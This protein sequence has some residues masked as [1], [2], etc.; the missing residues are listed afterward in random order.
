MPLTPIAE[1][2]W[3]LSHEIRMPGG[4]RLPVRMTV[5]RLAERRLLLHSPVPIDDAAAG[6]LAGLGEVAHLVAPNRLHHLW[7]APAAQ[8]WPEAAVWLA[9]GLAAR[10]PELSAAPLAAEAPPAWADELDQTVIAGAPRMEEHVFFHRATRTLI[11]SDLVFH[12][13]R[14]ANLRTRLLLW[15]VGAGGG[16]LATSRV[17]RLMVKDRAAAAG[18]LDRVHAWDIERIIPAHGDV[19]ERDGRAALAAAHRGRIG[20]WRALPAPGPDPS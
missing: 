2:L 13:T 3:G 8:R 17:W 4:A 10:Y 7:L 6:E 1:Q 11:C 14:P 18:S 19:V 20:R 15:L 12:V 9:P 16:R 5:V